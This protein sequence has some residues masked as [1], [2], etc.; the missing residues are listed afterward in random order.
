M[1]R[2]PSFSVLKAFYVVSHVI[3]ASVAIVVLALAISRRGAS[4]GFGQ[5]L[6]EERSSTNPDGYSK[7]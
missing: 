1:V 7:M 6:R 4:A 5:R 2:S 3:C